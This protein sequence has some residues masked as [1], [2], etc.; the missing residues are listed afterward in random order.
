MIPLYY[1][2]PCNCFN[3]NSANKY[4]SVDVVFKR[5]VFIKYNFLFPNRNSGAR[6]RDGAQIPPASDGA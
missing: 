4:Q 3:F 5:N 6:V 1:I 2:T